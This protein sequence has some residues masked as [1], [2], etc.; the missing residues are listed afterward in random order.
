MLEND[1][2]LIRQPEKIAAW[3]VESSD[4]EDLVIPKSRRP[5]YVVELIREAKQRD[6]EL[7]RR[8]NM[9]D[10]VEELINNPR[11]AASYRSSPADDQRQDE[12]NEYN[13]PSSRMPAETRTWLDEQEELKIAL[14]ESRATQNY[15]PSVITNPDHWGYKKPVE[16]SLT[17]KTFSKATSV[18]T[19]D[20]SR[21]SLD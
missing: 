19:T 8:G 16:R 7:L 3:R 1:L 6:R 5:P 9:P 15:V 10:M 2:Q 18:L 21:Q 14:V 13:I 17:T 12:E 4:D 11:I 20:R